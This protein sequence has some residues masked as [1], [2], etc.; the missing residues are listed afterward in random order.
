MTD[1]AVNGDDGVNDES[2]VEKIQDQDP[3]SIDE[4]DLDLNQWLKS[5]TPN[6]ITQRVSLI[7]RSL[8]SYRGPLPPVSEVAKYEK[9]L[10]GAADRVPI[11]NAGMYTLAPRIRSR[12][13]ISSK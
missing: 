9:L 10:P 1:P 2:K 12:L 3:E 13:A 11:W 5:D 8:V 4:A 6:E 7:Q